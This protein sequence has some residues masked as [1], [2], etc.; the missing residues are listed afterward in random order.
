M[1]NYPN[2]APSF[3]VKSNGQVVDASHIDSL[4]DEVTAIGG[5][6]L[7]GTAPLT[8]SNTIV[9]GLSI[10]G[11][12]AATGR[13]LS[14]LS[15]G[16]T[17]NLSIASTVTV[18]RFGGNSSGSTLTGMTVTGGNAG[19]LLIMMNVGVPTVVLKHASGSVSSN[20][21]NLKSGADAN[22]LTGQVS[23]AAYDDAANVWR[24]CGL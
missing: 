13:Q 14:A 19:R 7:N 2:S 6:L 5:G 12:F 18:L 10:L 23:I 8:S 9:A 11:G 16:N 22:F 17:D 21:F 4:Q 24:V 20:Q 1:A 15:T 3:T